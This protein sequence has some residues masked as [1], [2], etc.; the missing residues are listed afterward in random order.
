MSALKDIFL[1]Q[2]EDRWR[3]PMVAFGVQ[4]SESQAEVMIFMA[5]KAACLF[6]C[7][8]DLKLAHT[9]AICTSDLALESD[10]G[11]LSGK[12]VQLVDDTLIT[13]TTLYRAQQ[14]LADV[15][16][17]SVST[18]VFC[19][20]R[21]NWCRELV[22]PIEPYILAEPHEITNFSA[23]AVRAISIIPRPYLI[24]FPL[25]GFVRL[26]GL[27]LDP[28]LSLTA[29]GV[30]ELTTDSQRRAGASSITMTPPAQA[31]NALDNHLGWKCSEYAQLIKVRLYTR[32]RG[33]RGKTPVH[34]CRALPIIAF[35]PMT[36]T[37]LDALWQ[38]LKNNIGES[39]RSLSTRVLTSKEK[40]RIL[41]YFCAARLFDI[42]LAD[43]REVCSPRRVSYE[44][45]FRQVDFSFA[46]NTRDDV[47][48]ILRNRKRYPLGGAPRLIQ[49]QLPVREGFTGTTRF[50]GVDL[51]G[52]QA[53]LTE[54]FA[55]LFTHRELP[56]RKLIKKYGVRAFGL[57]EYHDLIDRLN[58]GI[59]LPELRESLSCVGDS[60]SARLYVSMFMDDAIDRG[61]AVP[62]TVDDGTYVYRAFRH[63][64]DV[65]F[66]EIE[67]RL[68]CLMLKEVSRVLDVP[69]LPRLVVEKLIVLLIKGGLSRGFIERWTGSLA[70]RSAAG[71]RFY[72]Q[73]AVAQLSPDRCPYHYDP[74][75]SLTSLL[76]GWGYLS[77]S[78]KGGQYEIG[79]FPERPPTTT[80][81]EKDAKAL[82]AAIGLALSG[83]VAG[84]RD[85][86]LT[87]IATCLSPM[88]TAAAI[89]AELH[90]F[91]SHWGPLSRALFSDELRPDADRVVRT[92]RIYEAVNSGL[93]KWRS[94]SNG[95]PLSML[96]AWH[97]RLSQSTAAVFTEA[98][99]EGAFPASAA[100]FQPSAVSELINTTGRWLLDVNIALRQLRLGLIAA[101]PNPVTSETRR[102]TSDLLDQVSRLEHEAGF[103]ADA[104]LKVGAQLDLPLP[105][106]VAESDSTLKTVL[107]QL[108]ELS[109]QARAIL[110]QVDAMVTPFGQPR[111]LHHYRHLLTVHLGDC[112]GRDQIVNDRL[113][114][115]IRHQT[116]EATRTSSSAELFS[117]PNAP[118][119]WCADFAVAATGLFGREWLS[120]IALEIFSKAGGYAKCQ[121]C[122]WVDLEPDERI[123][124]GENMSDALARNLQ[125]R[126]RSLRELLASRQTRDELIILSSHGREA[127][128]A[129]R[130]E[131]TKHTGDAIR[132]TSSRDISITEP[133]ERTYTFES[134]EKQSQGAAARP[135]AD[136]GIITI[137]P[138]EMNA[139]IEM[140]KQGADYQK[141]RKDSSVYYMAKLMADEGAEH[142][143]VATQQI[144]QGNRS[145]ILAYDRLCREYQP[146]TII[147]VGIGGAIDPD[148]ELCDVVVADQVIWYEQATV[149]DNSVN[150]KGET[151]KLSSWLRVLL[152]DFFAQKGYPFQL[153]SSSDCAHPKTYIGSIGTGEKVIRFRD[154]DVRKWL[155][156]FN[157]KCMV[158]ET[159]AGGLA[160]AFYETST[161]NS[162]RAKGYMVIRGI[163]DH[164]DKDRND[165]CRAIA[166]RNACAF[167]QKFLTTVPPLNDYLNKAEITP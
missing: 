5:R 73:G 62:I 32:I 130:N 12:H 17:A 112:D 21:E 162:Y 80:A 118:D 87:L 42:W 63:G 96:H 11:W 46:P 135:T 39:V 56:A 79:H 110:D 26:R 75:D 113:A 104:T 27:S 33:G 68:V 154:A 147:L 117:L 99:L 160:Q 72:L 77:E 101:S 146:V 20:D 137:V 59:S 53:K 69:H 65:K 124:R 98:V 143:V 167:L 54:P 128:E 131:L 58:Q 86:E 1:D 103:E 89:A 70:D 44:L 142:F 24:D 129:V 91:E 64:E 116:I 31:L 134:L 166:A 163:S 16:A 50:R 90:Y 2:F 15:G 61:I 123:V 144:E 67:A 51:L 82:G 92:H 55:T 45:D 111:P 156:E 71:I 4:L 22:N 152:N 94:H 93:W 30:D 23:Q 97:E 38:A 138:E 66:T 8:E 108:N 165:K 164:A 48:N 9:D 153:G 41:Q 105:G 29:W 140:L 35:D 126:V 149:T 95:A 13:G 18:T 127:V 52:V 114:T 57:S 159:E 148:I 120:R 106:N 10:L 158:L 141:E 3:R 133:R 60:R 161:T 36:S 43:I 136:I 19:V 109:I 151:S 100:N 102:T 76:K 78:S 84:Q 83:I 81:N 88:D 122:I 132:S 107:A 155:S 115:A 7:L 37:Q 47:I 74:G 6:H 139:V 125:R 121:I 28:V 40:L 49:T 25:F 119:I 34:F 157:Y 85:N 145:V 150:R 14:R